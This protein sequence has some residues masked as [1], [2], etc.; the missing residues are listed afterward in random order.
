MKK[1]LLL[2][3]AALTFVGCSNKED[4]SADYPSGYADADAVVNAYKAAFVNAFGQP[5]ANQTWGFGTPVNLAPAKASRRALQPSFNFPS[6][7]DASKFLTDVPAGVA[8]YGDINYG[9]GYAK[10]I[11]YIDGNMTREVNIWG[12]NGAGGTLYVK[13]NCDF[14]NRKFYFAGNSELYLVAGATLTLAENEGAGNLQQNTKIYI[15]EGAKLIAKGE[16]K[17]NN[18]LHIYNHGTIEAPKLST[19]S[20]SVLYNV[21]TVK[22]DGKISVENDLSV[23]V[24]DGVI[25]AEDLN[26]AGSGK[27]QNNNEVTISGT[28][29]INSNS[30]TWVNNGDYHTG[31]FLY[32]A[33]SD[34]VIN[35]CRLTIDEDFNIN[36]GDN[37]GNGNFKMD[38]NSGVVTKNFNGGGNWAKTYAG[39]WS[40]FNGGPFYIYMGANSVFKVTGT[41][42]MNATK[43]DYGI[44]GPE[45]GDYAVFQASKIVAGKANQGYEVTYGGN[46]AVVTGSHFA[47]GYSGTYPYIDFKGNAK[48]YAPGFN[49]DKA[50]DIYYIPASTCNPGF[51]NAPE[52][53]EEYQFLCRVF[54]E[55]LSAATGTDFD[56]NDVVFDVYNKSNGDVKIVLQAAGG[57]LPL[58]VAGKEVHEVFGVGVTDM[59]N[60]GDGPEVEAKEFEVLGADVYE[61]ADVNTKIHIMVTKDGREYELF[62]DQAEPASKFA[63][64]DQTA[65]WCKEYKDIKDVYFDFKQWVTNAKPEN[66]WKDAS[67]R[68]E[69]LLYTK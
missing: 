26:T 33:A 8:Y 3:I 66:W 12:E 7:A 38:A 27:F 58:T 6:D 14:S 56:F 22:V 49:A 44:Y 1:I 67:R 13:G 59:V 31:N 45:T 11:S 5:A 23:M 68:N 48:I 24:N 2:G 20:N 30:N 55:D 9:S 57:T 61:L 64:T 17:L 63:V 52:Q 21:G 10:G 65:K 41:A 28:T 47:N 18:G 54:A 43:A 62:A 39:T 40:T 15:A 34:E 36:L 29:F 42:T 50:E 53:P 25:T 51:G 32:N 69:E 60:T 16:L 35:N 4:F 46:L 19:N 37:P